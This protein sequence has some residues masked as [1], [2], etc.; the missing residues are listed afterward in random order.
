ML[1]FYCSFILLVTSAECYRGLG[2]FRTTCSHHEVKS[3][4]RSSKGFGNTVLKT[5][6]VASREKDFK[7]VEKKIQYLITQRDGL[8]EAYTLQVQS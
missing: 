6:N 7:E 3:E 5:E 8:R 2:L 1:L 4:L